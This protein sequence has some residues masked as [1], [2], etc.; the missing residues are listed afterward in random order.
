MIAVDESW[1]GREVVLQRGETL[2]V[3]LKENASTGFQWTIRALPDVLRESEESVE[4]PKGP[5]GR[6]G[7]R[8]L[9]FEAARPGVGELELEYR[10][11]WEHAPR[12]ARVFRLRARVR[13]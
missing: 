6:G 13:D 7:V 12:P 8:H 3:S 10:R 4:A 9:Y 5:P 2:K 11:S 1:N